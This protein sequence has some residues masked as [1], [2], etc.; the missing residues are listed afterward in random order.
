MAAE[1][2]ESFHD[3]LTEKRSFATVTTMLPNGLPHNTVV[4]I[5][6]DPGTDRVLVNTERG[7]RKERNVREDPRA[8]VLAPD[9]ESWL[10][11]ISVA[12]EVDEVRAE[13]ARE[14]IDELSVR[15]TGEDYGTPIQTERVLLKLRPE[16]VVTFGE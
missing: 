10:R 14:H 9:P 15:Y 11:W 12:G 4:W 7:R 1:I 5:D 8:G 16:H 3:V 2:P 6:Y 13:G